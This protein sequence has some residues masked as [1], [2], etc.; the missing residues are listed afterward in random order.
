MDFQSLQE[1]AQKKGPP[2]K[3]NQKLLWHVLV[4]YKLDRD[5]GTCLTQHHLLSLKNSGKD[6][7]AWENFRTKYDFVFN[8]KSESSLR[9]HL[10]EELKEHP[11]MLLQVD[12]LR[13]AKPGSHKRASNWLYDKIGEAIDIA[14]VEENTSCVDKSLGGGQNQKVSAN[15]KEDKKEKP[16]GSKE[17]PKKDDNPKKGGESKK[18]SSKQDKGEKAPKNGG[19]SASAAPA[20]STPK[21]NQQKRSGK[22]TPGTP[23]PRTKEEKAKMLCMYFAF[24]SCTKDKC[25]YLHDKNNLLQGPQACTHP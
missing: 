4:K 1:K 17:N 21:K 7:K 11:L 3:S 6:V 5:R 24:D 12:K 25:V 2:A 20:P 16:K 15:T 19:K 10:F 14:Q 9:T 23:R 18:D 22:G 8:S 13:C